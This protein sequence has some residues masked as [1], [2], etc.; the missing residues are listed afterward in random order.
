VVVITGASAGIGRAVALAFAERGASVGLIAAGRGGLEATAR[1]VRAAGG[2]AL[3]LPLDLTDSDHV[4]GAADAVERELGGI[5][6]WVNNALVSAPTRRPAELRRAATAQYLGGVHGMLAA[7]HRMVPRDRGVILQVGAGVAGHNMPLWA[8][9]RAAKHAIREFVTSLRAELVTDQSR[10]R[11][12]T[13][14]VPGVD[15][16]PLD[17]ANRLRRAPEPG[18]RRI[19]PDVAARG[20]VYAA[21][22]DVGEDV[23]VGRSGLAR[24]PHARPRGPTGLRKLRVARRAVRRW[25]RDRWPRQN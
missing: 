8:A 9:W 5:D 21:E 13:V 19:Q 11:V 20:V 4:D 12:T 15:G 6:V 3:V 7:V 1:D 17:W 18:P 23:V 14:H 16:L 25:A 22:N 24:T 2:R 10:V